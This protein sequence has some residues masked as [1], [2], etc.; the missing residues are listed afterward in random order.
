MQK[1][2]QYRRAIKVGDTFDLVEQDGATI[3]DITTHKNVS[4]DIFV[5]G[6]N[7]PDTK[8]VVYT[9]KDCNRR[10]RYAAMPLGSFLYSAVLKWEAKNNKIF[11]KEARISFFGKN[12]LFYK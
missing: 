2:E 9:F 6:D 12:G 8:V 10:P 7:S 3:I 11:T 4:N 1:K 5:Y